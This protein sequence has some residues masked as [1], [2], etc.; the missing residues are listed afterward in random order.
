MRSYNHH[1]LPVL[2]GRDH[3]DRRLAG[4]LPCHTTFVLLDLFLPDRSEEQ[5]VVRLRDAA[6]AA[7]RHVQ[8]VMVAG[9]THGMLL[10]A[11]VPTTAR[12][13]I[14]YAAVLA[15]NR[16]FVISQNGEA[17]DRHGVAVPGSTLDADTLDLW[18]DHLGVRLRADGLYERSPAF[19]A[20]ARWRDGEAG[21]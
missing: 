8:R 11:A 12:R 14:E 5:N 10:L 7:P 19:I 6:S 15:G 13:T 18:A 3:L 9:Q 17:R 16:N 20:Y 1:L 2:H 21:A 4:L